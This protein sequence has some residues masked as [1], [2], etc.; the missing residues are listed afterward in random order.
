MIL[1]T[2]YWSKITILRAIVF[3][4]QLTNKLTLYRFGRTIKKCI[5]VDKLKY[6][7][8][9][10]SYKWS[11]AYTR[12]IK[13]NSLSLN[14]SHYSALFKATNCYWVFPPKMWD[15]AAPN[16]RT[17]QMSLLWSV[18]RLILWPWSQ[19]NQIKISVIVSFNVMKNQ[20]LSL[21]STTTNYKLS[22]CLPCW[23]S[24]SFCRES[25]R[26]RLCSPNKCLHLKLKGSI[27]PEYEHLLCFSTNIHWP[28]SI[29]MFQLLGKINLIMLPCKPPKNFNCKI[30]QN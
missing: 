1:I 5:S 12:V 22:I 26:R 20:L 17:G 23:G 18:K 27:S 6:L 16:P 7:S 8:F 4:Y 14:A 29:F 2:R 19:F 30:N 24:N 9:T 10:K 13:A 11:A 25:N 28:C 21:L 15:C 3:N